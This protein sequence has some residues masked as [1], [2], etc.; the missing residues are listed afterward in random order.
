MLWTSIDLSSIPSTALLKQDPNNVHVCSVSNQE[1][2]CLDH[3][4]VASSA[5]DWSSMAIVFFGIFLCGIGSSAILVF[6]IAF[7][8]DN[9]DKDKSPMALSFTWMARL[10]GPAMGYLVG[11]ASLQ[12][13]SLVNFWV[14][15]GLKLLDFKLNQ[16]SI[17]GPFK[18]SLVLV[19][20]SATY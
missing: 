19:C 11:S 9:V 18:S 2:S 3:R 5:K 8:D 6:G 7:A 15:I 16:V 14:D 1:T 13:V 12:Y 10:I 17:F 4:A 20:N